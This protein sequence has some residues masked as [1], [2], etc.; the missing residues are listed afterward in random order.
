MGFGLLGFGAVTG[1][2]A[3]TDII[4]LDIPPIPFFFSLRLRL[5]IVC[6]YLMLFFFWFGF[7]SLLTW[8]SLGWD[9]CK[10]RQGN[11]DLGGH[12]TD[13]RVLGWAW[14]SYLQRG[15]F[16]GSAVLPAGLKNMMS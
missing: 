2:V 8:A 14:V 3:H 9:F 5:G 12:M 13:P 4:I 1:W 15:G 10:R 7:F 16:A 11:M 6:C